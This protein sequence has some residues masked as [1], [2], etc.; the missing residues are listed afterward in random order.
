MAR[1]ADKWDVDLPRIVGDRN[2]SL[3]AL[4]DAIAVRGI[5][6]RVLPDLYSAALRV[7]RQS[8]VGYPELIIM[9]SVTRE[10]RA[11]AAVR[12]VTMRAKLLGFRFWLDE[13]ILEN[14]QAE[15]YAVSS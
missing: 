11:P 3:Q 6:F 1:P 13:G 10:Q 12:S 4:K 9:G 15:E 7:Y 5:L 2:V 14:L 8:T